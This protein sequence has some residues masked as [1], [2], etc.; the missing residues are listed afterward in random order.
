MNI[1][2]KNLRLL[3]ISPSNER[4]GAEEYALTLTSAAVEKGW[5]V[6]VA[7]PKREKTAHLVK[8]FEEKGV[9]YHPLE[10]E[11]STILKFKTIK[12]YLPHLIQTVSLLLKNKPDVVQ[13]V[14]PQLDLCLGSILACG[15]LKIPTGVV[16]QLAPTPIYYNQARLKLYEWARNRNQQWIAVSNHNRKVISESFQFSLEQVRCIYNGSKAA[17]SVNNFN[18]EEINN[19]RR[20]IKE[21]LNLPEMSRLALTVGRLE[22]QKGHIDLIPAIPHLL[23]EFPDVRFV[24]VGDGKEREHILQK[25]RE[26]GVEDQVLF[27]GYRSDVPKLLASADLFLFP[28]RYEGQ[29][30]ALME[31]MA[32]G[33]PIV[34][35]D[36]C[37]IPE[38]IEN[39]VHGLLFRTGDSCDLLETTRWA[40]RH[41]Q[42]M[43]QMAIKAKLRVQDFSEQ[44]MVEETLSLLQ[45][46]SNARKKVDSSKSNSSKIVSAKAQ[47]SGDRQPIKVQIFSRSVPIENTVG[48]AT[49]VL[50]FLRYLHH[51]GCEVEVGS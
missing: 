46:L 31:A 12:K 50:D 44:R 49:Y 25:I 40:L 34:T 3:V 4:G 29:P 5:D 24:W 2:Q 17:L 11:D 36:A 19:L 39:K 20:Q 42:Q 8:S 33:L 18:N 48:N 35:S 51:A 14:L 26:Y 23:K 27:L 16:F 38:L 41:P 7:F 9:N 37:G 28:T 45:K 30:F 32:H 6:H 1:S 10:I 21:E 15:L 43:Q 47:K 22:S 13:I